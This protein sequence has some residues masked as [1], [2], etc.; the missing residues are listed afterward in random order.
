MSTDR[1]GPS[2]GRRNDGRSF[3]GVGVIVV[4]KWQEGQA[5]HESHKQSRRPGE[6]DQWMV[7][8]FQGRFRMS[9]K[10]GKGGERHCGTFTRGET[11]PPEI[12]RP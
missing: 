5:C 11:P 3:D 4:G 6:I 10:G 1:E 12:A 8:S 7:E 2:T 9:A